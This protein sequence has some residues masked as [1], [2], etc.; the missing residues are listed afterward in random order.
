MTEET[1]LKV[2]EYR[3][4]NVHIGDFEGS[5]DNAIK[6]LESLKEE[7]WTRLEE[8]FNYENRD[9]I[10]RAYVERPETDLEFKERVKN[11]EMRKA[12]TREMRLRQY[13]E[14]RKEFGPH[15]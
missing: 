12:S 4:L 9:P 1:R 2:K 11:E 10:L 7:G 13:E 3:C 6:H 14:L 5:I 15:D 8:D